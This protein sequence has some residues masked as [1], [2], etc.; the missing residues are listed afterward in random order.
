MNPKLLGK[1]QDILDGMRSY[2]DEGAVI[3]SRGH[4]QRVRVAAFAMW[5]F[6]L[7]HPGRPARQGQ[8]R[9][10]A[11][12]RHNAKVMAGLRALQSSDAD[13]DTA[14]A[15]AVAAAVLAAKARPLPEREMDMKINVAWVKSDGPWHAASRS[16]AVSHEDSLEDVFTRYRRGELQPEVEG[17][18][19]EAE[20][21]LPENQPA[22]VLVQL[23]SATREDG[24]AL[25]GLD[26]RVSDLWVGGSEDTIH[27]IAEAVRTHKVF[28]KAFSRDAATPHPPVA[29]EASRLSDPVGPVQSNVVYLG[30]SSMRG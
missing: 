28:K 14:A 21:Y 23:G 19:V 10:V 7:L 3:E 6:G 8:V 11:A 26:H 27:F 1:A 15:A 9:S 13:P 20:M 18:R 4:V 25:D 22:W 17:S 5:F 24:Y 2:L 30:G 16:I 12:F 29:D